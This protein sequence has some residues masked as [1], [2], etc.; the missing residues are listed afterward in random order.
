MEELNQQFSELDGALRGQ[1]AAYLEAH[2]GITDFNKAMENGQITSKL[3]LEAFNA[4]SEDMKEN[5]AGAVG[6][7]QSRID[8]LNVQQLDNISASL[9]SITLESLGETFGRFGQQMMSVKLMIEQFLAN[10]ATTL[11]YHQ[12]LVKNTMIVIGG[13]IQVTVVGILGAFKAVAMLIEMVIKGWVLLGQAFMEFIKLIPGGKQLLDGIGNTFNNIVK[14]L[15]DFT[16][17]WLKVGDGALGGR[18]E[19]EYR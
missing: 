15:Q 18:A 4:I 8:S 5:L 7:V 1:I 17:G 10:L 16:D 13:A 19:S 2:H 14:G 11:P 9:N 6:E 12:E 3:F